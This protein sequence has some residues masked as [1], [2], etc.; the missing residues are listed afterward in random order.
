MILKAYVT[1]S[2]LFS[3]KYSLT[4][5]PNVV[6]LVRPSTYVLMVSPVLR[7]CCMKPYTIPPAVQTPKKT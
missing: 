5:T 6:P 1:L 7:P 3:P 2:S 4:P